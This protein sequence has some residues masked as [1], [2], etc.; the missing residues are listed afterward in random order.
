MREVRE[1][2]DP[3]TYPPGEDSTVT[4]AQ[5]SVESEHTPRI[6]VRVHDRFIGALE[7]PVTLT[8]DLEAGTVVIR[9]GA[10]RAVRAGHGKVTGKVRF[11]T[12]TLKTL[13]PE[14]VTLPGDCNWPSLFRSV[15][16][17]AS[18]VESTLGASALVRP[19]R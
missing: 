2:A 17:S 12:V 18:R 4:L 6:E 9:D 10:I 19:P 7:F 5:Y 8:L 1:H 14:T 3:L 15:D 13:G 16:W 11:A